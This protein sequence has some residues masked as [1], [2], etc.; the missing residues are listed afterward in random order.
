MFERVSTALLV[1]SRSQGPQTLTLPLSNGRIDTQDLGRWLGLAVL[2]AICAD[3]NPLAAFHLAL[4]FVGRVLDFRLNVAGFH[5]RQRAATLVDS[6][7]V[8]PRATFDFVR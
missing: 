8:L 6:R 4:I 1:T 2:K 3:N 5:R 7:D